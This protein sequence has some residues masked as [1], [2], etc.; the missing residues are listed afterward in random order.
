[1]WLEDGDGAVYTPERIDQRRVRALQLGQRKPLYR[2][3]ANLT[4]YQRDIFD[5]AAKL[6]LVLKRPGYEYRY[7]W[8]S[9]DVPANSLVEP[10]QLELVS[11]IEKP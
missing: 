3:L 1:V 6:T 2:G 10:R 4:F 7:Q 11:A 5:H 9:R 8:V